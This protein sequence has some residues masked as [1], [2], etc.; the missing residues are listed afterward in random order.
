MIKII[1][2]LILSIILYLAKNNKKYDEIMDKI[3]KVTEGWRDM[4]YVGNKDIITYHRPLKQ[5]YSKKS[6]AIYYPI[7]SPLEDNYFNYLNSISSPKLSFFRNILYKV[8]SYTNQGSQPIIF[9]YAERPITIKKTDKQKVKTLSDTVVNMINKFAN[10]MLKIEYVGT[11]NEVHEETDVQSRINFDLKIKLYYADSEKMG[12]KVTPDI[13]YIQPE[14]IFEKQYDVLPEDQFFDKNKP[15]K[16][17]AY[18]SKLIVIG[19]EN[20]G[21]LAGRYS[22]LQ[23]RN[24]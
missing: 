2:I 23:K 17:R 18:L 8:E 12:K 19:S 16:F 1:F 21:F 22:K 10:P 4:E 9:N 3:F 7:S 15:E 6:Q 14:F 20:M 24:I 13:L 5:H 11:S